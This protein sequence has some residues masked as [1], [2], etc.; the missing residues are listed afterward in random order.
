MSVS[1]ARLILNHVRRLTRVSKFA[2]RSLCV[3]LVVVLFT[4][5]TPAAPLVVYGEIASSSRQISFWL[6]RWELADALADTY[7]GR[8]VLRPVEQ[9]T[10]QARN[11]SV[12]R[13][14][15]SP[16]EQVSRVGK[17]I[18]FLAEAL[19]A[20]NA[21]VGGV[22]FTWEAYALGNE[23]AV[24]VSQDGEFTP[25]EAGIYRIIVK[26]AGKTAQAHVEVS[27]NA[28]GA[29]G[30]PDAEAFDAGLPASYPAQQQPVCDINGWNDC[31]Y[32]TI[33]EPDNRI[34]T[35]PVG[36]SPDEGGVNGNFR[37]AAPV[38]KLPVRGGD[39]NLTL[40]YNS[41]LW[42]KSGSEIFYDIDRGWPAPGWTLGFG[43]M[44]AT[45]QKEAMLIEPDG[46][47]HTYSASSVLRYP[48][49]YD[50]TAMTKDGSFIKYSAAI[51]PG[52]TSYVAY[53]SA[54]YPDGMR[55]FYESS[56]GPPSDRTAYAEAIDDRH[57]NIT[58][59]YYRAHKA[60]QIEKIVD[61]LGRE[62]TFHYDQ[63][64]LLTAI[65]APG[66]SK[67][68][69]GQGNVVNN[70]EA[71][72]LVRITYQR[73]PSLNANANFSLT[74]RVQTD[75]PWGIRAI[76]Y[77]G[78]GDGYWFG[79]P[80]SYSPYGMISTIREQRGMTFI[81]SA[82][83]PP[84]Q[85]TTGQGEIQAGVTTRQKSYNYA[86]TSTAPL[87]NSP[88]FD[89]V[90][91]TWDGMTTAPALTQY[92]VQ[93]DTNPFRADVPV[94]KTEITLPNAELP[95]PAKLIQWSYRYTALPDTD[96]DKFRD[97][98]V[99]KEEV[100]TPGGA[101]L[102]RK[103]TDWEKGDYDT[104]RATRITVTDERGQTLKKEF[105]YGPFNQA[106]VEREFDYDGTTILREKRTTYENSPNYT[107]NVFSRVIN[108]PK[109]VETFSGGRRDSRVEYEYDGVT[110]AD[111]PGVIR[112]VAPYNSHGG[113]Y[114]VRTAFRGDVT[115][116]KQYADAENL[117]GAITETRRYDIVGNLISSTTDGAEYRMNVFDVNTQYAYPSVQ[118]QGHQSDPAKR[119]ESSFVYDFNTGLPLATTDANSRTTQSYYYPMSLRPQETVAPTGA[120]T[121]YV[122]D[123]LQ[124]SETKT[125]YLTSQPGA[126]T[127]SA[128]VSY[129]NGLGQVSKSKTLRENDVW[130]LTEVEYDVLGRAWRES[131]S[132]REGE[133]LNWSE[134]VFDG[135]GRVVKAKSPD[136]S[137]VRTVYN[138]T[139]RPSAAMPNT[140]PGQTVKNIDAWGRERWS[141]TDALGR[142]V[143]VVE[144][145]P[146]GGGT[147]ASNGLLT[148]YTYDTL[149][150]LT[151]VNQGQQQRLF[152]YD[153]L[154]RLVRQKLAE[155]DAVFGNDGQYLGKGV[156]GAVW[157]DLFVYDVRSNLISHTDARNVKATFS[158]ETTPNNS[159]SLNRL[160]SV[161]YV[162]QA[163]TIPAADTVRYSYV[164][165]GD[166]SR[167]KTVTT[168]DAATGE[169]HSKLESLYDLEGRVEQ[170]T[171]TLTSRP[172]HPQITDYAYDTLGRVKDL[173]YPAQYK[174]GVLNP[175]RK[176]IH[177]EYEIGGSLKELKVNGVDYASQFEYDASGQAE[178]LKVG[179]AG[180]SQVTETYGF[181]PSTGLLSEQKI[182]RGDNPEDVNKIL[183]HLSYDYL[184]PGTATG[185]TGQLTKL[186]D[187]R[188]EQRGRSYVY[189]MLGR[190]QRAQGGNP[191]STALWAQ[192]YAYDR[193]GNRTHVTATG[194]TASLGTPAD[195]AVKRPDV[196]LAANLLPKSPGFPGEKRETSTT[197][198][199]T[200]PLLSGSSAKS[201]A[202]PFVPGVP[203]NV[204]V[205]SASATQVVVSWA[206]PA[207]GAH[208][209]EVERGQSLA[210][211]Y[212][213]VG[214]AAG[215]ATTFSDTTVTGGAAYLYRVRAVD[216]GGNRS[217]PSNIALG[218]AFNFADDPIVTKSDHNQ[219]INTGQPLTTI[220]ALHITQLRAAVNAVRA[221]VPGLGQGTWTHET[222]TPHQTVVTADDVRDLRTEL[223]DA[224]TALNIPLPNYT[225]PTIYNGQGGV[226]TVIKRDHI[227]ELRLAATRG[228]S[229]ST[230]GGS[231]QPVPADG[232]DGFTYDAATNRIAGG[233][234][235]AAGN[236]TRALV[237]AN[238]WQRYEYDAANRLVTVKSDAG[239]ILVR[240][241]YGDGNNRLVASEGS[242]RTYY[243][244]CDGGVIAEYTET[245][246]TSTQTY[247]EWSKSYIYLGARLLATQ[248]PSGTSEYVEYY[249]PDNSGPRLITNS[250]DDGIQEQINLP[251]GTA[252]YGESVGDGTNRRFTSYD[253][254]ASTGLD[255][256]INRFYDSRQGRFTQVDPAGFKA[257][258]K[259]NP[260]SLNLYSYVQNDP[261]NKSDPDG[262]F[263]ILP[264]LIAFGAGVAL[265]A[266]GAMVGMS[267]NNWMNGRPI[268][269]GYGSGD[270]WATVGIAAGV[271]GVAGLLMP[272]A[273]GA[274]GLRGAMALGMLSNVAQYTLTQ[275]ATGQ[276]VGLG[277]VLVSAV[278]GALGGLIG[279]AYSRSVMVNG[280]RWYDFTKDIAPLSAELAYA[281]GAQ[282]A[283]D[284][285][286]S[287]GPP[288]LL[289]GLTGAVTSNV[290]W[291]T[292]YQKMLEPAKTTQF[293]LM[294]MHFAGINTS[295][296][297]SSSSSYGSQ[298]NDRA[299]SSPAM[300]P[301]PTRNQGMTPVG[302]NSFQPMT[303]PGVSNYDPRTPPR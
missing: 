75:S 172:S 135:L 213:S 247:P 180:S 104:P 163:G 114:D 221:L 278:S 271:G 157:S 84:Q 182:F 276:Q 234:Y 64:D 129:K 300:P 283:V 89:K 8:N 88:V 267:L 57:G 45:A 261:V 152:G 49:I 210:G 153:S 225:D 36:E 200:S 167:V 265:G 269:D 102:Y 170:K 147:V 15:I 253:R 106:T 275:Y 230:G 171:L 60:P 255:Y 47:R 116:V 40:N 68:L 190:L 174:V 235:D 160:Q 272:W 189:D 16:A 46:T 292:F 270:F 128:T 155:T 92:S 243:A 14:D 27:A 99:Y 119:V 209:Y 51:Y 124:M 70:T 44:V 188:L 150:N 83:V 21:A 67:L 205:T 291:P 154:G 192:T 303:P 38:L 280:L 156:A 273:A 228:Q 219:G 281:K 62:I 161:S 231:V 256:A 95:N 1:L 207:G 110:P 53:G 77:P 10:Q 105:T 126:P 251:F 80:D 258:D 117:G 148:T 178:A 204:V 25:G 121:A 71:R 19:D 113:A 5:Q 262:R 103:E 59:I 233:E 63:N 72:T 257:S 240:Y 249:H 32:R 133:A 218:T 7:G 299:N 81:G 90:T 201:L 54:N 282:R 94:R 20:N 284:A 302:V 245:D 287:L 206:P 220:Q 268:F 136:G 86:E 227:K 69:D 197:D 74:K 127:A 288:S 76:Y 137:E 216:A 279:G 17:K 162:V 48:N 2:S 93:N 107:D 250:A 158:Y 42:H 246:S 55:V 78:T 164:T 112:Q 237:A 43:K 259:N 37:I 232:L 73:L 260:Q 111:A 140:P 6:H 185:R 175:P 61:S 196:E 138:E 248:R 183:V 79:A 120:T 203:A 66:I 101:L 165:A 143:E 286:A 274:Y 118:R 82:P 289:R 277:G 58:T 12:R 33:E 65:T 97:G 34:G 168:E 130:N 298:G 141:R 91:E 238:V 139:A 297:S 166:L 186:I 252:L 294:P 131:R 208:H 9:Q 98:L 211:T 241:T 26:G 11:A 181:D 39:L 108:L 23:A 96:Q 198:A 264:F 184:R 85:G 125:T 193:Y 169:M 224:L 134:K 179:P 236:Q 132:Y 229:A 194:N 177:F 22:N 35:P 191:D 239:A 24:S 115:A 30:R 31:N 144:P 50:L 295:S 28:T 226:R 41:R 173:K 254:A 202:A 176:E 301:T 242:S 146:D 195:P 122:Y 4:A 145:N 222:L 263:I 296:H 56:F 285:L 100:V 215:G 217:A 290:D 13:I 159:D 18:S 52:T 223:A 151:A 123:D 29:E 244:W 266:L 293:Q 87:S 187:H 142:L 109:L 214:T 3:A 149:G 212:T 199:P